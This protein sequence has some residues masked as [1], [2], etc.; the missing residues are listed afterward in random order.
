[1]N[2]YSAQEANSD[3]FTAVGPREWDL[4]AQECPWGSFYHSSHNLDF[5]RDIVGI[6]VQFI[7][8]RNS[9]G[10]AG[11]LAFAVQNG[12]WGPVI[13]SLPFFGSYG[14]A[15]LSGQATLDTEGFLYNALIGKAK[16]IDAL[17]LNVITSPFARKGHHGTVGYLLNPTF[18]EKRECQ[19]V[20]LPLHEGE[21][22]QEYIAKLLQGFQGRARTAYRKALKGAFEIRACSREGEAVEF[23]RLHRKNMQDKNGVYKPEK[24]FSK[25]YSLSIDA[26]EKAELVGVFSAH[27]LIAGAVLFYFRDT[28]EY[29]TVCLADDYRSYNP[30]TRIIVEKMTDAALKGYRYWNFG[31]TWK[32]QRSLYMFKQSFGAQTLEYYYYT[33][34]FRGLEQVKKSKAAKIRTFYPYSFVIPFS[35]LGS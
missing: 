16:Q 13:N 21:S 7:C 34:F 18:I 24:F 1:M 25:V 5:I 23:A 14:D 17:C 15:L 2:T 20:P 35:E 11:G 28:V 10:L 6:D 26:P 31:G 22:R 4:L 19:I 9:Q 32:S 12:H 8:V 29:H 30:L 27:D 33:L 3:L